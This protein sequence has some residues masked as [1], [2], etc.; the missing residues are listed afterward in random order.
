MTGHPWVMLLGKKTLDSRSAS[1]HL[2]VLGQVLK[3][4]D[5]SSLD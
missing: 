3:N 2:G 1:S 5:G 4:S